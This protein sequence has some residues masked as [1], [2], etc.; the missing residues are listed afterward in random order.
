MGIGRA[1]LQRCLTA[2][3][4]ASAFQPKFEALQLAVDTNQDLFDAIVSMCA[5]ADGKVCRRSLFCRSNAEHPQVGD[6]PESKSHHFSKLKG[7]LHQFYRDWSADGKEERIQ[8]YMPLLRLLTKY[9]PV[10]P[11]NRYA[12]M[13]TAVSSQPRSSPHHTVLP[14]ERPHVSCDPSMASHSLAAPPTTSFA[15]HHKAMSHDAHLFIT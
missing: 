7:T 4:P 14:E 12:T 3:R 6:R 13:R 2:C 9:L 5:Q 8:S 1:E 15:C 10:T 11:E